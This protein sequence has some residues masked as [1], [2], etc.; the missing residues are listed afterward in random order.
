[1]RG[2]CYFVVAGL[3]CLLLWF[4]LLLVYLFVR[5]ACYYKL[6]LLFD[7]NCRFIVARLLVWLLFFVLLFVIR[8]F[9]F[10]CFVLMVILLKLW[11]LCGV[12]CGLFVYCLFFVCFVLLFC[13]FVACL[14]YVG[15]IVICWLFVG[16]N[17][18][19]TSYL[20]LF[21]VW[22]M[23]VWLCFC[24]LL[25]IDFVCGGWCSFVVYLYV[26][27]LGLVLLPYYLLFGLLFDCWMRVCLCC[28]YVVSF[29]FCCY[30]LWFVLVNI[31]VL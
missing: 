15:L 18:V 1:M 24:W 11:F 9:C 3:L 25:V 30:V 7:F 26:M 4:W 12:Y 2:L 6:L 16:F 23:L 31:S 19:A 29:R 17:S 14:L 28:D 10:C 13:L 5:F 8:C 22:M 27:V 20:F 21:V